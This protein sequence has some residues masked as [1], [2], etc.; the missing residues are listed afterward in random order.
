VFTL[1][2]ITFAVK[3]YRAERHIVCVKEQSSIEISRAF[4]EP[5]NTSSFWKQRASNIEGMIIQF[6]SLFIYVLSSNVNG[7]LESQHEYKQQ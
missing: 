4:A 3:A 2:Q 1:L 7:Q 6:N 5:R